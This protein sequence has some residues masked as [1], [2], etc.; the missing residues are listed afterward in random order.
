[1]VFNIK[2]IALFSQKSNK[3]IDV[4][5]EQSVPINAYSQPASVLEVAGQ[6]NIEKTNKTT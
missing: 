4:G 1:M 5:V 2:N 3:L 6:E